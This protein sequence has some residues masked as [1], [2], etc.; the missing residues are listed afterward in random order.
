MKKGISSLHLALAGTFACLTK[1]G[2]RHT[3]EEK[4]NR[5]RQQSNQPE[6]PGRNGMIDKDAT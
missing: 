4:K 5:V 6:S 2:E 1:E 3:P